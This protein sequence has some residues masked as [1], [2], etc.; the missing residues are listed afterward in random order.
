MTT[1]G[2]LTMDVVPNLAGFAAKLT[3][4]TKAAAAQAQGDLSLSKTSKAVQDI[5]LGIAAVGVGI[6]AVSIKMATDFQSSMT[7]LVTGAGESEGA[8]KMVGAG[9]LTMA[10]QVGFSADALAKGMF[11]VESAGYHGAAG[12]AVMQTAAEGAKVGNAVLGTT[13]NALTTIMTDYHLKVSDSAAAMNVLI[14]TVSAGKSHMQD[15]AGAVSTV[16]P[17]A[18]A[19]GV[20]LSDVMGAM[21]TMTARGVDAATAATNL[22]FTMMALAKETPAG[23]KALADV[24][25]TAAEVGKTLTQQGLLQALTLVTDAVGKKFPAGSA[26]YIAAVASIVGGTRGMGAVLNLTGENLAT[27]KANV[28]GIGTQMLS[29]SGTVLGFNKVQ[30]DTAFK[31]AAAKA[32]ARSLGIELGDVLLPAFTSL[33]GIVK[34][35]IDDFSRLPAPVQETGLAVMVLGGAAVAAAPRLL[36]MQAL[37]ARTAVSG[38]EA[39]AGLVVAADGERVAGAAAAGATLSVVGLL[40]RLSVVAAALAGIG[41]APHHLGLDQAL[42]YTPPP[43]N[44][45]L[46]DPAKLLDAYK[47]AHLAANGLVD[48]AGLATNKAAADV[49]NSLLGWT[50]INITSQVEA[51]KTSWGQLDT[52]IADMVRGGNL[53]GANTEIQT[54]AASLSGQGIT[55]DQVIQSFPSYQS[56]LHDI[57]TVAPRTAASIAAVNTALQVQIPTLQAVGQAVLNSALAQLDAAK[58][59]RDARDAAKASDA[60]ALADILK[61]NG[62][63]NATADALDAVKRAVINAALENGNYRGELTKLEAKTAPGSPM[64]VYLDGLIGQLDEAARARTIDLNFQLYGLSGFQALIAQSA[65]LGVLKTPAM[66]HPAGGGYILGGGTS[67]SDS[68]PAMESTG[69]IVLNA[70]TVQRVGANKLLRLNA[71]QNPGIGGNTVVINNPPPGDAGT[72]VY[73]ALRRLDLLY[74]A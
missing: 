67:T 53:K 25:L 9:L 6:A 55:L 26:Q 29:T 48:R 35:A 41:Y 54:I 39:G 59:L 72:Q 5:G 73:A 24:G 14:G 1:A 10:G 61:I 51:A 57:N 70:H 60:L 45:L 19:L 65:G 62:A 11:M 66:L 64:R 32:A 46:S 43:T 52:T 13:A 69:E 28:A 34:P 21:A 20:G 16:L 27:Y 2:I 4:G 18:S 38:T 74:G 3:E 33:V 31:I 23:A 49:T 17:L 37:L 22:K 58:R 7:T 71:G 12:L 8:I 47:S 30:Q 42:S 36:A 15:L 63:H 50:G 40:G 44:A 56:A 68:V